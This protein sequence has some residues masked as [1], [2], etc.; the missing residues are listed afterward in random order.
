MGFFINLQ[1]FNYDVENC[2]DVPQPFTYQVELLYDTLEPGEYT[3]S[4]NGV[5]EET[6]ILTEEQ[7]LNLSK[8]AE[9]LKVESVVTVNQNEAEINI[10]SGPGPDYPVVGTLQGGE[11]VRVLGK[12]EAETWLQIQYQDGVAWIY[13]PLTD[14][15]RDAD[16]PVL[17]PPPTPIP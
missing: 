15:V 7:A 11:R 14:Y 3:V 12:T 5:A 17:T 16:L 10:R 4:V 6:F 9:G 1:A 13:T 8:K 2:K